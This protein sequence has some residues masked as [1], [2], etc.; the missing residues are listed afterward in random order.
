MLILPIFIISLLIAMDTIARMLQ[1]WFPQRKHRFFI[2]SFL[3]MINLYL[4]ITLST[5]LLGGMIYEYTFIFI[6]AYYFFREL[7]QYLLLITPFFMLLDVESSFLF[8]DESV[9]MMILIGV[10]QI[11]LY[12]LVSRTSFGSRQGAFSVFFVFSNWISIQLRLP[13]LQKINEQ[14]RMDFRIPTVVGAFLII[15]IFEHYYY[16][17]ERELSKTRTLLLQSKKDLL[18]DTYNFTALT[19][20]IELLKTSQQKI[21]VSMVDLDCFKK[22][23][24]THGHL[25]GNQVLKIFVQEMRRSFSQQLTREQFEIYRFGGEEFCLFF[26]ELS[27]SEVFQV[28]EDFRQKMTDEPLSVEDKLEVALTFSAGI[29]THTDHKNHLMKTIEEA[30]R[31]CYHSKKRGRNQITFSKDIEEKRKEA[32]EMPSHAEAG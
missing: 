7:G 6:I 24:D 13:E 27:E 19:E 5:T 12:L 20:M 2:V 16:M 18:T 21:V 4:L 30:D 25:T 17:K 14:M 28:L 15:F 29:E 8:I 3:Y 31:A 9:G 32:Q 22:V 23:N 11:V 26:Y 1:R 10:I